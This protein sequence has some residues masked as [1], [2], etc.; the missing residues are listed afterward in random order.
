MKM[1]TPH[2]MSLNLNGKKNK[3]SRNDFDVLGA[4][5]KLTEKQIQNSYHLFINKLDKLEWWINHSFLSPVQKNDFKKML[6]ER[7]E[8]L[9]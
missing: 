1:L 3:I 8:M 4:N 7:I 5:L 9:K 2:Q 6:F